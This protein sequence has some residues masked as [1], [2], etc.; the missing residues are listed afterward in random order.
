MA[1]KDVQAVTFC[2]EKVRRAADRL[3]QAYYFGKIVLNEWNAQNYGGTTIPIDGG[4]VEDGSVTDGRPVI[5]G[6]DVHGLIARI[7]A[8]V[9]DLEASTNAKLN[10]VIKVAVHLER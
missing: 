3:A 5:T 8:L 9:T 10:T 1:V 4:T 2:N 7:S 6:N